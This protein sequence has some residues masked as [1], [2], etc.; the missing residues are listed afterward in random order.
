MMRCFLFGLAIL[1]SVI[2]VIAAGFHWWWTFASAVGAV[3]VTLRAIPRAS[4]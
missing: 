2:A 3:V 4:R 1:D